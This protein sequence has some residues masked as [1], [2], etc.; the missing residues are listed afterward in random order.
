MKFKNKFQEGGPVPQEQAPQGGAPAPAEGGDPMAE[1]VQGAMQAVQS[2][3]CEVAMQVCQMLVELAGGGQGAPTTAPE[4]APEQA[5][6]EPVYRMGGKLVRR[7][8]Y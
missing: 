6:T 5:T 1:L 8:N 4:E 7:I 3:D 2:G